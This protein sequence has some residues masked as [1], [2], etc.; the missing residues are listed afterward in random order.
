MVNFFNNKNQIPK[1][2]NISRDAEDDT[3]ENSTMIRLRVAIINISE[4]L[5]NFY[6]MLIFIFRCSTSVV[7]RRGNG[8]LAY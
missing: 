3:H 2:S 4:N 7:R 5:N 6:A 8:T 1:V